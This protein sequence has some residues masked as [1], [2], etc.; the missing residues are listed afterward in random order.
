MSRR[1]TVL[2]SKT[3]YQLGIVTLI[4]SIMWVGVGIYTA[5]AKPIPGKVDEVVLEPINTTLDKSVL[6]ELGKR[7]K[8]ES[9]ALEELVDDTIATGG[10]DELTN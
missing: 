1:D 8:I 10:A 4:A 6:D 3:L 9:V 7:I 5:L 2:V